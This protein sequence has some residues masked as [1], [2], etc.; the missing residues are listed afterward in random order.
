MNVRQLSGNFVNARRVDAEAL[1]GR[2]RLTGNLE[3]NTFEGRGFS[4]ES[5]ARFPLNNQFNL[6][7]TLRT[8]PLS[9]ERSEGPMYFCRRLQ[10]HRSFASLRMTRMWSLNSNKKGAP[11]GARIIRLS[12]L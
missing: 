8:T 3:Q 4:H 9:S 12:A 6:T 2:Q 11:Q 1:V 7:L 10:L 5:V